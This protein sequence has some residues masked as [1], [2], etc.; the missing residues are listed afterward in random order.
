MS[1][2]V[3]ATEL[4]SLIFTVKAD[5]AAVGLSVPAMVDPLSVR[6]AGRDPDEILQALSGGVPPLTTNGCE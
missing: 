6:P 3:A 4:A 2:C 5:V 1:D